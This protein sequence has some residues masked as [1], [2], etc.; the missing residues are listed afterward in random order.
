MRSRAFIALGSNLRPRSA[1]LRA[2][3]G[4]LRRVAEVRSVS[5][6]HRTEAVAERGV[7]ATDPEFLNAAAALETDLDAHG[8][9][10]ALLGIEAALGRDRTAGAAGPRTIDLDLLLFDDCIIDAPGL[11]VPHPR[12]HRRRFV[13]EPLVE[14]APAAWHPGLR[15]TV[16]ELRA[17]LV[18]PASGRPVS[19]P[20]PAAAGQKTRAPS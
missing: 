7:R 20:P 18:V 4:H 3:L 13:L 16:T 1:N 10:A 8:L 2:A 12:M 9:L 6:F 15:K 19:R 5:T 17:A 11:V 14:I